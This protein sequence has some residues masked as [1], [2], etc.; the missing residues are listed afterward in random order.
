M[1]QMKKSPRLQ[2]ITRKFHQ[3]FKVEMINFPLYLSEYKAQSVTAVFS[4]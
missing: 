2:E 4:Y 1:I 3:T